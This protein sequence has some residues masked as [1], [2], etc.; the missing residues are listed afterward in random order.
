[1]GGR[2]F[3]ETELFLLHELV[4]G[5][6]QF[7]RVR[8][9]DPEGMTYPEFLVLMAAR[10]FPAPTQEDV[11]VY[12][13]M[14]T[15]LVSQRVSSLV[16]KGLILQETIPEN[17]RKVRLIPTETGKEKLE[18][19]YGAMAHCS[20]GLFDSLGP[21]RAAFRDT[22][23]RLGEGLRTEQGRDSGGNLKDHTEE[24]NNGI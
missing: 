20:D 16:R 11:S 7:A 14:S 12:L 23:A 10:E 21:G 1:M 19:I 22:L 6:D 4:I 8:I 9:L 5:L 17:K 15:S 2:G 24:N 18:K 13:S 3:K